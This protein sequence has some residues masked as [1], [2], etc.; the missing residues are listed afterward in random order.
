MTAAPAL[1]I[2]RCHRDNGVSMWRGE[3][4]AKQRFLFYRERERV[5]VGIEKRNQWQELAL[6]LTR[7][8]ISLLVNL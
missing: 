5:L 8:R 6:K 2:R 3:P 4:T 1:H 7:Q